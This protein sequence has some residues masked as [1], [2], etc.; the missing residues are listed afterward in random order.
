MRQALR[1]GKSAHRWNALFINQAQK[2]KCVIK[3][4]KYRLFQVTKTYVVGQALFQTSYYNALK[5]SS[6]KRVS[7]AACARRQSFVTRNRIEILSPFL[8]YRSLSF[9]PCTPRP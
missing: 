2:D 7:A 3:L 8:L 1:R 6:F 9:S 4:H 5:R